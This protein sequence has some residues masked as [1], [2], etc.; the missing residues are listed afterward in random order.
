M[1]ENMGFVV[2]GILA[3]LICRLDA[4]WMNTM[5]AICVGFRVLYVFSY[6]QISSQ[7]LSPL[8]TLWFLFSSI[9]ILLMY[10]KA[11]WTMVEAGQLP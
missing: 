10:W 2:G 7:Q 3:G 5:C 6:I 1:L 11:G 9:P 4:N 8:R